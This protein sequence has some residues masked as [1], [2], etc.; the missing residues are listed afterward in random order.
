MAGQIENEMAGTLFPNE[1]TK[2]ESNGAH[3]PIIST[4]DP[5]VTDNAPF[6]DE[7]YLSM[8]ND[9]LHQIS[10]LTLADPLQD[11]DPN[12][13]ALV[14]NAVSFHKVQL[15]HAGTMNKEKIRLSRVLF[16]DDDQ[17]GSRQKK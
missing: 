4:T 6:Y 16:Y 2:P 3:Q 7:T 13:F 17:N 10:A 12:T 5:K 14:A 15:L 9:K 1:T 11:I 8:S